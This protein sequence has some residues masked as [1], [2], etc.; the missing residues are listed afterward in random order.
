MAKANIKV[1]FLCPV[2]KVWNTI[3]NLSQYKWRSD[4]EKIQVIDEETFIE[5]SKEG[6]KTKFTVVNKQ[7]YELWEFTLDNKNI[8]GRWTGKFYRHGEKTTLDFT[9]EVHAKKIFMAPF[10]G[11]YLRKQQRQYFVDL[12]RELGCQEASK[13]QAF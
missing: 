4:I 13:I 10:V 5:V 11:G 6:I 8:K 2:E 1:T 7:E 12:K 9:E 3:T